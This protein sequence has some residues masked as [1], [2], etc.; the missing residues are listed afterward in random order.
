M[1]RCGVHIGA[2]GGR[3]G[4]TCRGDFSRPWTSI[5]GMPVIGAWMGD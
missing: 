2:W 5:K 1:V 3:V 4:A